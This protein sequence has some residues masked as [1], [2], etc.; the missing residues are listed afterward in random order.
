MAKK[1]IKVFSYEQVYKEYYVSFIAGLI[2]GLS[3]LTFSYVI[4]LAIKGDWK[5]TF[6]GFLVYV[7]GAL[8]TFIVG[9]SVI[10]K[11]FVKDE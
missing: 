10:K 3:A 4:P 1:E 5:G 9:F 6:I 11:V 2:G 7:I 8:L